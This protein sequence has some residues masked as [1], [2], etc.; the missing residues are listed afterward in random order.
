MISPATMQEAIKWFSALETTDDLDHVWSEFDDWFQASEAHRR[1][2]KAVQQY[3]ESIGPPLNP[4]WKHP[5]KLK[6]IARKMDNWATRDRLERYALLIN[7]AVVLI[8]T[9]GV[10]AHAL[11]VPAECT[12]GSPLSLVTR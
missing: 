8:L 10:V 4:R 1:A 5:S 3:R 11:R 12:I 9:I 6:L 7:V 2:Y